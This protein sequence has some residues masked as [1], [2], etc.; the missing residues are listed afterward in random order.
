MERDTSDHIFIVAMSAQRRELGWTA[1]P[2]R[3]CREIPGVGG[4]GSVV[5]WSVPPVQVIVAEAGLLSYILVV[6]PD[7][8]R[9]GCTPSDIGVEPCAVDVGMVL[10]IEDMLVRQPP[11]SA[12]ANRVTGWRDA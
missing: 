7:G 1:I 10:W 5:G 12:S 9:V 6:L 2:V 8:A 3:E 4:D 11:A